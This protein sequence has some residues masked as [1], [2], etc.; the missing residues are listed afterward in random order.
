MVF[1][2]GAVSYLVAFAILG[3]DDKEQFTAESVKDFSV[4]ILIVD[5]KYISQ[6]Q[7]KSSR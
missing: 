3:Q 7:E 5:Y 2:T 6:I 1:L 4:R